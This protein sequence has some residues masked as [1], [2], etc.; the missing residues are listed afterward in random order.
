MNDKTIVLFL[1]NLRFDH[2]MTFDEISLHSGVSRSTV[3]NAFQ[4]GTKVSVCQLLNILKCFHLSLLEFVYAIELYEMKT[5]NSSEILKPL[6]IRE[7]LTTA[8]TKFRI[9]S[10]VVDLDL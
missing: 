2:Q 3:H 7:C 10:E 4:R 9:K 5:L 8:R 6:L 1:E